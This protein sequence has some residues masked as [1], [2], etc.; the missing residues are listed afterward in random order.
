MINTHLES[1]PLYDDIKNLQAFIIMKYI[2]KISTNKFPIILAGD[3]NSKPD[4]SAYYGITKGISK[5]K[6]DMEDLKYPKPFIN[7]PNT[8]TTLPMKS[9]YKEVFGKEPDY[10]NYTLNFK[11]TLDYIFFNKYVNIIAALE[12]INKE[13]L[14]KYSSIPNNDFPSDHF[15]QS[16]IIKI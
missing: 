1:K 10:S 8:F 11:S 3:F 7:T 13:Y 6:F 15:L 14:E 16:T 4:S 2:E 5:N 9:A 12:E